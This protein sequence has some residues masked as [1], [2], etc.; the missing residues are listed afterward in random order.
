MNTGFL[1][2]DSSTS[3][4]VRHGQFILSNISG[5]TWTIS[6]T[7]GCTGSNAINWCAGAATLGSTL[8]SVRVTTVNGTDTFDAGSINILYE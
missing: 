4:Y 5:N 1:T 2:G 8:D 3:S 6:G 7:L